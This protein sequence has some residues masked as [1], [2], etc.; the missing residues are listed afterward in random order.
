MT[1][2]L[3]VTADPGSGGADP[4]ERTAPDPD[5]VDHLAPDPDRDSC[6]DVLRADTL[7]APAFQRAVLAALVEGG[8]LTIAEV[9]P[10]RARIRYQGAA[11]DIRLDEV[12]KRYRHGEIEPEAAAEEIKAAVG[13]PGAA[14]ERRGPFPRL[15]RREA[16]APG[17]L[18][19]PCPFDNDLAIVHVW[20]VPSGHVP[21]SIAEAGVEVESVAALHAQALAALRARTESVP[22]LGEGE[23]DRLVISYR[24]GDGLDAAAILLPDLRAE[25][26]EWVPGAPRFAIPERDVLIV[27]GDADPEVVAHM[28]GVV[29]QM[30]EHADPAVRLTPRIFALDANGALAPC[31]GDSLDSA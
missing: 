12:F 6:E 5:R 24:A 1:P 22:A 3:P 23:G 11:Y 26:A 28:R 2:E 8:S 31:K 30:F 14:V 10:F 19:L 18:V 9:G 4:A 17:V 16:I 25:A 13:V 27:F 15:Q 21:I 7:P 20:V 29:R